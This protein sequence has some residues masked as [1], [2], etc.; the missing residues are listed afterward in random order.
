M[1]RVHHVKKARK[2]NPVVKAGESYYW[3][4]FRFGR[5]MYSTTRPKRSQLTRSAFLGELWAIEDNLGDTA[6]Q[7]DGDSL[8]GE[9]EG[10]RDECECSLENMPEQLRESSDSGVL[11]QERIY[12][13]DEWIEAI[14]SIDWETLTP[15][16]AAEAIQDANPGIW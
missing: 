15:E 16:E 11:L 10:L 9:L 14:Q 6:T 5:K 1:P 2:D 13:L 7:D 12:A 3:W 4:K 8:V